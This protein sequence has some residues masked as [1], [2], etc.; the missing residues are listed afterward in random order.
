MV[1]VTISQN[2][3][4]LRHHSSQDD[5]S[6]TPTTPQFSGPVRFLMLLKVV[7]RMGLGTIESICKK[8]KGGLLAKYRKLFFFRGGH[9][10]RAKSKKCKKE[11]QKIL[12]S[13][14]VR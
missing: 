4:L 11:F 7:H 2:S 1:F 8:M 12:L 13:Q 10:W 14:I 3:T 9:F 5:Q 6:L